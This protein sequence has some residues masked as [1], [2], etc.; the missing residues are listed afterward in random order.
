ML[1]AAVPAGASDAD[2]LGILPGRG[3][4]ED[5]SLGADVVSVFI[6]E[7]PLVA[8]HEESF[9]L[10]DAVDF[11]NDEVVPY[12]D[13]I[14]RGRYDVEFVAG[15]SFTLD[16]PGGYDHP[17]YVSAC[18][19]GATSRSTTSNTMVVDRAHPHSIHS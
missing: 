1:I 9:T 8:Q 17:G 6:C 2:P 3:V 5:L 7:S 11:A 18:L 12:Y 4:A 19:D 14:S 16:V 13:L 15:G 10:Q